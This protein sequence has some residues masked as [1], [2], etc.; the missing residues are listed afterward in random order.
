MRAVNLIPADLRRAG[1]SPGATGPAVYVLLGVLA[2]LVVLVAVWTLAG[3]SVAN[4]QSDLDRVRA[5]AAAAEVRAGQ[6]KPYT[7]FKELR[8]KRLETVNSLS[9]SRFNWP[10]VLREVSRVLPKQVWLTDI[11]GTVAPGVQLEDSGGIQTTQLRNQLASP[12]LEIAGCS[13]DQ[14]QVARW[15]ARLRSVQGVS[16]VTLG[17]TEKADIPVTK[18]QTGGGNEDDSSTDCRQGNRRIPRFELII[19]FEASTATPSS[20]TTGGAP[21]TTQPTSSKEGSK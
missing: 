3:R 14:E 8:T 16:R 7:Q 1:G 21:Q 11:V 4:G 19:F 6:L 2:A 17:T 13:T 15:L 18:N 12:A 9:R 5:E 20:T 10:F